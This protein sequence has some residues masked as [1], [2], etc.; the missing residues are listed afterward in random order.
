MSTD[1]GDKLM[2]ICPFPQTVE[3]GDTDLFNDSC[4]F[5]VSTMPEGSLTGYCDGGTA[6][7]ESGHWMGLLHTFEGMDCEGPGD[8]I[9]DTP[10][11]AIPTSGCPQNKD[12]CPDQVGNDPINNFMDYSDDAW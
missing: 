10:C 4:Q 9:A 6:V 3:N 7:H 12:T 5:L 1:F 11:E 8:F 2:G